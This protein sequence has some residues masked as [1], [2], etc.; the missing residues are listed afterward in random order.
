MALAAVVSL[1]TGALA[2][3]GRGG[4]TGADQSYPSGAPRQRLSTRQKVVILAGAAALY[5]LYEQA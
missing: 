1:G 4:S 3:C 2:G 5:Y